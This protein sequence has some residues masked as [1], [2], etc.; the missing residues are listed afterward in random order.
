MIAQSTHKFENRMQN[1]LKFSAVFSETSV[2]KY[3]NS[4]NTRLIID[5]TDLVFGLQK[6]HLWDD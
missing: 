5:T 1:Q 3:V 6:V 4:V 2:E